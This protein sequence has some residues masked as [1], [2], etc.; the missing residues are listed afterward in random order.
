MSWFKAHPELEHVIICQRW[1][2]RCGFMGE[3]AFE[4]KLR[5]FVSNIQ[6][7]GKRVTLVGPIPEYDQ[8]SPAHYQRAAILRGLGAEAASPTC[9]PEQYAEQNRAVLP[10]L[11]R[12]EKDGL[13]TLLCPPEGTVFHAS[14]GNELLMYDDNHFTAEGAVWFTRLL[15]PGLKEVLAPRPQS[16]DAPALSPHTTP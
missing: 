5:R 11:Q 10:V 14:R 9:Q 15:V 4:S 1:R 13:C 16:T 7:M 6:A 8:N 2:V 3:D 12:M